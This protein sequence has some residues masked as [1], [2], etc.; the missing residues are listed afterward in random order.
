MWWKTWYFV[1]EHA[2]QADDIKSKRKKLNSRHLQRLNLPFLIQTCWQSCPWVH[3][4]DSEKRDLHSFYPH[5][6]SSVKLM[7]GQNSFKCIKTVV[8]CSVPLSA[9]NQLYI[10]KTTE[11]VPND[12][13]YTRTCIS[14]PVTKSKFLREHVF[15]SVFKT[16]PTRHLQVYDSPLLTQ[17]CWQSCPWEHVS[18]PEKRYSHW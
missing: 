6:N 10:I 8:K 14:N 5:L 4:C 9:F 17:I 11:I 16:Y 2:Y 13:Q 1:Q 7:V 3:A 18:E 15:W 12:R